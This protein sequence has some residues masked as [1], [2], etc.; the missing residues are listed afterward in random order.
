MSQVRPD[1][2]GQGILFA[3]SGWDG[4]TDWFED[5]VLIAEEKPFVWRVEG[6]VSFVF[7][8]RTALQDNLS[9][10]SADVIAN[11]HLAAVFEDTKGSRVEIKM[12]MRDCH[13]LV[14]SV[15]LLDDAAEIVL[16]VAKLEPPVRVE[17]DI[18]A[19]RVRHGDKARV[20]F[21]ERSDVSLE[22]D[23][24]HL[25]TQAEKGDCVL[26]CV[27]K[28]VPNNFSAAVL[29]EAFE[30]RESF[31][32]RL[33]DAPGAF[34]DPD[35]INRMK[36]LL[37]AASVIK[38]NLHTAQGQ[39]PYNWSTPD[40]YPHRKMWLWDSAFHTIG[41]RFLD[42]DL[43]GD[44][45]KA[46]LSQMQ[47]NGFIPH[48]SCP[49][50]ETSNITQAPILAWASL[51]VFLEHHEKTFLRDVYPQLR[52]F[53][54]FFLRERDRDG[55]GLCEWEF[56]HASGM[57]NSPRFDEGSSFDAVDLNCFLARDFDAMRW[58][59]K[60][61]ENEFPGDADMWFERHQTI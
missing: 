4:T 47:D 9:L 1:I 49:A 18:E 58:I 50:G 33:P 56:R 5:F 36:A 21:L 10:V 15:T 55:D 44:Q 19:L 46:V 8:I 13:T 60:A 25:T 3:F 2:W 7:Q 23:G 32:T 40:R 17:C 24:Y 20:V 39:I 34:L 28:S 14:G 38:V 61:L 41:L 45:V 42:P 59:A 26:F 54:E 30:T 11:D 6:T 37:K 48:Y 12:A 22:E 16:S 43:A 29:R 35:P 51:A 52:Q 57:D 53:L 31:F 27:G